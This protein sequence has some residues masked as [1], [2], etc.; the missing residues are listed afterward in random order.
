M[1]QVLDEQK[2]MYKYLLWLTASLACFYREERV[3]L[4]KEE[5]ILR[6]EGLSVNFWDLWRE[7]STKAD[8][9]NIIIDVKQ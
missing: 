1:R 8:A 9:I 3:S 4:S 2:S 7:G 6:Y 5:L